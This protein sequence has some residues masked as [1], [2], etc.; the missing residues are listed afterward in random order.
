[1]SSCIENTHI[2][3]LI[4]HCTP[5]KLIKIKHA[6]SDFENTEVVLHDALGKLVL[7]LETETQQEILSIIDRIQKLPG[8]L[9]ATMVYH[10]LDFVTVQ[11]AS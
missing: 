7:L 5:D 4:V 2:S 1:M 3:S 11:R 9:A 8:V 6:I 10:E